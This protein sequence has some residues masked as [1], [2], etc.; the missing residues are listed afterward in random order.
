M[1]KYER[2][3]DQKLK[4][5]DRPH[6]HASALQKELDRA[7]ERHKKEGV[8]LKAEIDR[9]KKEVQTLKNKEIGKRLLS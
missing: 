1:S 8:E 4:E 5:G 9:L 2:P 7:R 3:G 6:S